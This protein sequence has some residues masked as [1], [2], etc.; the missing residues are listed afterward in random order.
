MACGCGK[1]NIAQNKHTDLD[2]V[3]RRA[4]NIAELRQEDVQIY[5]KEQ[6]KD[7][8]WYEIEFP[9][10]PNRFGIVKIIKWQVKEQKI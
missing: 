8:T 3:V 4:N 7:Y 6:N 10:N 1:N 5:I 2:W 9:L